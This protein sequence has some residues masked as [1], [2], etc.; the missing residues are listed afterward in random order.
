MIVV[1][2]HLLLLFVVVLLPVVVILL[3]LLLFLHP[4][5]CSHHLPQRSASTSHRRPPPL[6]FIIQIRIHKSVSG[7]TN[8]YLD[9]QIR[10][11][12]R[13]TDRKKEN[14]GLYFVKLIKV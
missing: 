4:C 11:R 14:S 9:P 1:I 8:P 3:L 7:S 5:N 10:I 13:I 6:T 2:L 12:I